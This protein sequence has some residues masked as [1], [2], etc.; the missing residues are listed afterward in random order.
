VAQIEPCYPVITVRDYAYDKVCGILNENNYL[1]AE[2]PISKLTDE[3]VKEILV[4][5]KI[6]NHVCI[7]NI[8]LF[9]S[10]HASVFGQMVPL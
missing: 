9:R 6:T 1:F 5:L 10:D 8:W 4:S 3:T 2:L 7:D